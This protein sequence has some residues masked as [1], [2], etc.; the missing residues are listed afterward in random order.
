MRREKDEEGNWHCFFL[1]SSGGGDNPV[2]VRQSVR[3]TKCNAKCE[4]NEKE[5]ERSKTK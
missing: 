5:S 4:M 2:S 1:H 3:I